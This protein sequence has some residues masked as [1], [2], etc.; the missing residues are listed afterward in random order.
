MITNPYKVL[1]VPDG[2]S[3]KECTRA[4]KK[5]AKKYHPDLNPGD[6]EAERKMA[7]INAAYDQI[8]NGTA[9]NQSTYSYTRYSQRRRQSSSSAPDYLSSAAQLIRSGQYQQA[10]NLLNNIEDR[11]AKWYYLSAVANMSIGN[12]AVAEDHIRTAYAKEPD[13]LTYQQAYRDITHG[14]NPIQNDPFSS[15]F[16]FRDDSSHNG[17]YNGRPVYTRTYK[18][19]CLSRII[20]IILIIIAIRFIIMI[21]SSL[22]GLFS[23]RQPSRSYQYPTQSYTEQYDDSNQADDSNDYAEYYFGGRSDNSGN[24]YEGRCNLL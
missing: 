15:F 2:A 17:N 22:F 18:G 11:N 12:R 7:E 23:Y 10:I 20:K 14:V 13:N 16:D 6:K 19:G 9:Q 3:E 1:G 24:P 4:Y 8:K 5:L 21:L